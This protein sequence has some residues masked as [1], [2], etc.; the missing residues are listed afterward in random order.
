MATRISSV[1]PEDSPRRCGWLGTT[2][3]LPG[4]LL[5]LWMMMAVVGEGGAVDGRLKVRKEYDR[6]PLIVG[7]SH[8]VY[9]HF[10]NAAAQYVVMHLVHSV[11]LTRIAS[12][13]RPLQNVSLVDISFNRPHFNLTI[14]NFP[15][16]IDTIEAY[17]PRRIR[18]I[19]SSKIIATRPMCTR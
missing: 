2:S 16:K 15:I 10:Y 8:T 5:L 4:V 1:A 19:Y 3:V 11:L 18:P 13:C 17:A 9:Y 14:L 7:R 12:A 6:V